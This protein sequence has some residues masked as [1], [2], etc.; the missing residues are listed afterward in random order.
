MTLE[1]YR[2]FAATRA[3]NYSADVGCGA[4]PDRFRRMQNSRP[5]RV[6]YG[7]WRDLSWARDILTDPDAPQSA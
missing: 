5:M 7:T 4:H 2:T 3:M 6:V 1:P